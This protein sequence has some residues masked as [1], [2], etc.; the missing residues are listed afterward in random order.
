MNMAATSIFPSEINT[1]EIFDILNDLWKEFKVQI[2]YLDNNEHDIH[3]FTHY[4]DQKIK[5]PHVIPVDSDGCEFILVPYIQHILDINDMPYI[6]CFDEERDKFYI[7]PADEFKSN[8]CNPE[9]KADYKDN[10]PI[11]HYFVPVY[12]PHRPNVWLW[13]EHHVAKI[14]FA[15]GHWDQF[16]NNSICYRSYSS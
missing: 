8:F 10:A 2:E 12:N 6:V 13:V 16:D 14:Y 5:L 1:S 9:Y 3:A 7:L 15:R 11:D 4:K